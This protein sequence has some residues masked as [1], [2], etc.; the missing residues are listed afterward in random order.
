[1]RPIEEF[2]IGE[3]SFAPPSSFLSASLFNLLMGAY[4]NLL[5]VFFGGKN[6]LICETYTLIC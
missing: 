6:F 4:P 3:L 5:P 1:M 2:L